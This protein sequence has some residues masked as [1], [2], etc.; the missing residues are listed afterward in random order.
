LRYG[1]IHS[2]WPASSHLRDGVFAVCQAQANW[3]NS[4]ER[5]SHQAGDEAEIVGAGFDVPASVAPKC[6][7]T[8][9]ESEVEVAA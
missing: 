3:D 4:G 5:N 7:K 1:K 2:R 8:E 9:V 6:S